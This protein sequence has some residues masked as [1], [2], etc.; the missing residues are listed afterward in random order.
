MMNVQGKLG[1]FQ[2][3]DLLN[4]RL[5]LGRL[6]ALDW[7]NV[8]RGVGRCN[9]FCRLSVG[10]R[11]GIFT[12]LD[13]LIVQG[14]AGRLN[15]RDG[16][17]VH[18]TNRSEVG[19]HAR[20][21]P[22]PPRGSAPVPPRV[23]LSQGTSCFYGKGRLRRALKEIQ[24]LFPFLVLEGDPEVRVSKLNAAGRITRGTERRLHGPLIVFLRHE[25]K[26]DWCSP[27]TRILNFELRCRIGW[28]RKEILRGRNSGRNSGEQ[29]AT[30]SFGKVL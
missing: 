7:L 24:P 4:V 10:N 27:R 12:G 30:P 28:R 25:I 8:Y 1:T 14:R 21:S 18:T 6:G 29:S 23:L 11:L 15:T 9:S 19:R 17:G 3:Q 20:T 16:R 26:Y 22:I 2:G 5:R 13:L